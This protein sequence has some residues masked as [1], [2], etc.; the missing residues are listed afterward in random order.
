VSE[1]LLELLLLSSRAVRG[2][3]PSSDD[4]VGEQRRSATR[5]RGYDAEPPELEAAGDEGPVATSTTA[6][7]PPRCRD[8]QRPMRSKGCLDR[9]PRCKRKMMGPAREEGR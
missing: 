2:S 3:G 7:P 1:L 8:V 5:G 4:V 6:R 9:Q